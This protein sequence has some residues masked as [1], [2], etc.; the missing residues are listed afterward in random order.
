MESLRRW[1]PSMPLAILLLIGFVDLVSTAVLHRMGLVTE[2]NPVMKPLIDRSEW[3]FV[4]VKGA[5]LL[6]AWAFITRFA[7]DNQRFV[8]TLCSIAITCYLLTWIV[9]FIHG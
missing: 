1:V 5:T 3:L 4:M 9:W 2:L 8:N 6:L 7:K